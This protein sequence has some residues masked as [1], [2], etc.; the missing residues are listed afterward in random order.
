MGK[1][2]KA[3]AKTRE[4]GDRLKP[5]ES[6]QSCPMGNGSDA[7][8]KARKKGNRLK[9]DES[10]RGEACESSLEDR[11]SNA[12]AQSLLSE[13]IA[14]LEGLRQQ[15]IELVSLDSPEVPSMLADTDRKR[16]TMQQHFDPMR[17]YVL[18]M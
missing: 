1:G 2:S 8:V 6:S 16:R 10:S 7:S 5:D 18:R 11:C 9:P 12:E 4:E 14:S 17:E 13:A 15:R 3:S